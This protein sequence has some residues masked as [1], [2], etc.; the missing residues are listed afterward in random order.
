MSD[1]VTQQEKSGSLTPQHYAAITALL[2]EPDYPSAAAKVGVNVRTLYRWQKLPEFKQALREAETAVIDTARRRLLAIT[3]DSVSTL[4]ELVK[5][6]P[7]KTF[8]T[9]DDVRV[10]RTRL[11]A[12]HIILDAITKFQ[13]LTEFADLAAE[14]A[15]LKSRADI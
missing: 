2:T 5:P 3:G 15:E 7:P 12:A 10:D 14:V 13:S 1:N 11:R 4:A 8:K 9:A 6:L